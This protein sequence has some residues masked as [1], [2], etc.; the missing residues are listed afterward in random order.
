YLARRLMFA[1]FPPPPPSSQDGPFIDEV[2]V[3]DNALPSTRPG[4][5]AVLL[6]TAPLLVLGL[7]LGRLPT[8]AQ[9]ADPEPA[10]QPPAEVARSPVAL[11]LPADERRLLTVNQTADTVSLV[12]V[13]GG[14]V[15]AEVPVGRRPS[16]IALTP[17]ERTA[18]VT[19]TYGHD[20]T[21][22]GL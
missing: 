9:P 17:D 21:V 1:Q 2:A 10:R 3:N 7:A 5:R 14:K 8:A 11:L 20:L 6:L 12:E 15:L 22:L 4:P 16:G 19:N 13:A 18:L